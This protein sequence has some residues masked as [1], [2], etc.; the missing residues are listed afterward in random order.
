VTY[1][2]G[3]SIVGVPDNFIAAEYVT[4]TIS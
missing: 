3:N 2:M 1:Y 4:I